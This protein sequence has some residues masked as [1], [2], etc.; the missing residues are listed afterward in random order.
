MVVL[1]VGVSAFIVYGNKIDTSTSKIR[2]KMAMRKNC[3]EKDECG[4]SWFMRP[5]SN[6]DHLSF[7]GSD[8]NETSFV[9]VNN[10]VVSR[11]EVITVEVNFIFLFFLLIGNQSY[12]YTSENKILINTF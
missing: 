2:N 4:L 7:V 5:H 12:F 9:I 11:S 10:S 6:G 3:M 1:L 8:S